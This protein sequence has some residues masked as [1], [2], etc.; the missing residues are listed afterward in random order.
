MSSGIEAM[1]KVTE[2]H[3]GKVA[4]A[5]SKGLLMGARGNSGVIL[6]Q[7]FRGISKAVTDHPTVDVRQWAKALRSGIDTAYKAVMKPVEGTILTVARESAEAAVKVAEE[8]GDFSAVLE[9]MRRAAEVTLRQTPEMLSVLKRAGVV[10]SGGKGLLTIYEAFVRAWTGDIAVEDH[11]TKEVSGN[12]PAACANPSHE[13]TEGIHYGYCT[14]FIIGLDEEQQ[15]TFQEEAFRD[16]LSRYGDSL[17]VVA[18]ED[19]VKVHL[20][21]EYPGEVLTLSQ[22]YGDLHHIKID[23]MREQHQEVQAKKHAAGDERNGVVRSQANARR[24]TPL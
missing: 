15:R 16:E 20:H 10:D 11:D 19:L 22:K 1:E 3:V 21:A 17:V 18:D 12:A 23:N 9:E 14:E 6:S 13:Q 7:L 2:P 4:A 5:F 8:N 24:K